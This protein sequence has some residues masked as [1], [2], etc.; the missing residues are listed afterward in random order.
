MADGYEFGSRGPVID[1]AEVAAGMVE[2]KI[3]AKARN[4]DGAKGEFR[5]AERFEWLRGFE[6]AVTN[7]RTR[8]DCRAHRQRATLTDVRD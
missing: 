7:L 3:V 2:R 4:R 6:P 5:R 1:G 8:I